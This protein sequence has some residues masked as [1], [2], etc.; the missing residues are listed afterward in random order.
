MVEYSEMIAAAIKD[1]DES[2]GSSRQAI[3]KYIM[4]NN[5]VDEDTCITRVKMQ[6]KRDVAS[7]KLIQVKGTGSSGLFRLA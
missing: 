6:L 7:G 5:T 4:E 1:S 2:D 3:V